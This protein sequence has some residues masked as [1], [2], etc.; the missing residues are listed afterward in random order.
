MGKFNQYMSCICFTKE[1]N[2]IYVWRR[3]LKLV[4]KSIQEARHFTRIMSVYIIF[5]G[6]IV[7]IKKNFHITLTVHRLNTRNKNQL[8]LPV[9]KLSCQRGVSYSAMNIVN[10][11][12]NNVKNF[13]ND[14]LHFKT[15]V[16]KYLIYHSFQLLTEFFEQHRSSTYNWYLKLLSCII[17]FNFSYTIRLSF[18]TNIY[19]L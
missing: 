16:C 7:D 11:L 9:A 19:N 8:H 2:Q 13:G 10:R 4:Q 15:V 3:S 14:R 5:D 6:I 17:L 12:P 1:N 18:I